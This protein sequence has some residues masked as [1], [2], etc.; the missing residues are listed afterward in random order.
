MGDLLPPPSP[1]P[2]GARLE[3]SEG[4]ATPRVESQGPAGRRSRPIKDYTNI[5]LA[6]FLGWGGPLS[7]RLVAASSRPPSA[8]RHLVVGS[9]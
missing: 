3:P 9:G 4:R 6:V 5:F 7:V 2:W 8:G 1:S